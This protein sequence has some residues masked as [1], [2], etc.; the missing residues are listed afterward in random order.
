MILMQLNHLMFVFSQRVMKNSKNTNSDAQ[1]LMMDTLYH[2]MI[3]MNMRNFIHL[4]MSKFNEPIDIVLIFGILIVVSLYLSM[5]FF[6][7]FYAMNCTIFLLLSVFFIALSSISL[8][9]VI[10]TVEEIRN[11]D[12]K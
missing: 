12:Q 3:M 11:D 2:K 7:L 9:I 1:V 5:R 6:D 4:L 8:I 10:K